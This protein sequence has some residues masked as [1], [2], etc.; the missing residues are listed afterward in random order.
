MIVFLVNAM[1]IIQLACVIV[2]LALL[3]WSIHNPE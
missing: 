1:V 3:A 2:I